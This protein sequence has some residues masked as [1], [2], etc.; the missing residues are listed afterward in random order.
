M[1]TS[2]TL[3]TN[4]TADCRDETRSV[5]QALAT[6]TSAVLDDETRAKCVLADAGGLE[7]SCKAL[8]G[9]ST[10]SLQDIGAHVDA[11]MRGNIRRVT[12]RWNATAIAHVRTIRTRCGDSIKGFRDSTTAYAVA[13][14][15][16]SCGWVAAFRGVCFETERSFHQHWL[17]RW[18]QA[19]AMVEARAYGVFSDP[20]EASLRRLGDPLGV[21][22]ARSLDAY[23][24]TA[25]AVSSAL[26]G[27][28][29]IGWEGFDALPTATGSLMV[30]AAR[31]AAV[32]L[33]VADRFKH[34]DLALVAGLAVG[35][36][37][38]ATLPSVSVH[39]L[40]ALCDEILSDA[41]DPRP[42][43]PASGAAALE[44]QAR[45]ALAASSRSIGLFDDATT[46]N[47]YSEIPLASG[48]VVDLCAA[49]QHR[50]FEAANADKQAVALQILRELKPCAAPALSGP[51][52]SG[53][54]AVQ[55]GVRNEV[56]EGRH[57][58]AT[59]AEAVDFCHGPWV[60]ALE[61]CWLVA[62]AKAVEVRSKKPAAAG[63]AGPTPTPTP[64]SAA[65]ARDL[66]ARWEMYTKKTS[67]AI[68]VAA[69]VRHALAADR[70][71]GWGE[72]LLLLAVP[73]VEGVHAQWADRLV[74]PCPA[75]A[76]DP[77]AF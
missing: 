45:A 71:M 28:F 4:G 30:M 69:A 63:A 76:P 33:H 50:S 46:D 22:Y 48:A 74:V 10:R 47:Q 23:R 35:P 3:S 62:F 11:L 25:R 20:P 38:H 26:H 14:I 13:L 27:I 34:H 49:L 37:R 61:Q 31:H 53:T 72:P 19:T 56:L 16:S 44:V 54:S 43:L 55:I 12:E 40:A 2:A 58:R 15:A 6:V 32:V 73:I 39:R 77:G 7:A 75:S 68:R 57:A 18:G 67:P 52:V 21:T 24:N 1:V 66:F 5:R 51:N 42:V 36:N 59:R 65:R 64:R 70:A 8:G 41:A 17:D 60:A 9:S 29:Q